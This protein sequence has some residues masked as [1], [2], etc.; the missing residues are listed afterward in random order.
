MEASSGIPSRK[1]YF[2]R[3]GNLTADG[4]GGRGGMSLKYKL[5]LRK[6]AVDRKQAVDRK[7]AVDLLLRQRVE[8]ATSTFVAVW[9][10]VFMLHFISVSLL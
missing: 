2:C 5:K 8:K 4:E 3:T 6:L 7:L 10:G 9:G 1:N